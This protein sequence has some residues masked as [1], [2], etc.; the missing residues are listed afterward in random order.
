MDIL[1]DGDCGDKI[2]IAMFYLSKRRIIRELKN[3]ALR[4][5]D[6]KLI[7]DANRDAFGRRKQGIPNRPVATELYRFAQKHS[8]DIHIRWADTHGEQLHHK[9][10]CITN[11]SISKYQLMCGSANWTRRNLCNLNLEANL[12]INGIPSV[13]TKFINYFDM[14]WNNSNGYSYTTEYNTVAEHGWKLLCK[15]ILYH[16]Q[17][18]T[19]AST[20]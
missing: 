4:G 11:T 12:L 9:V 7:L 20:F 2:R 1:R 3:A 15:T 6:I 16:I 14:A 19:G 10:I 13:S 5:A 18:A 8:V 17:E